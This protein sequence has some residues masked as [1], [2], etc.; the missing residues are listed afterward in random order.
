[1][2]L[3]FKLVML[4]VAAAFAAGVMA[5]QIQAGTSRPS[6][7]VHAWVIGALIVLW[8][9]AVLR[10][11]LV[12]KFQ[13]RDLPTS[14]WLRSR[15]R[16]A[17]AVFSLPMLVS[18]IWAY[19]WVAG[20]ALPHHRT[21]RQI[22]GLTGIAW[23]VCLVM[24]L[25]SPRPDVSD[26]LPPHAGASPEV[27]EVGYSRGFGWAFLTVIAA[28]TVW[29]SLNVF[30]GIFGNVLTQIAGVTAILVWLPYFLIAAKSGIRAVLTSGPVLV[31]DE[32]GITDS[33]R[34]PSFASWE[35][36]HDV[37]LGVGGRYY[38]L[39][40]RFRSG[41]TARQYV[42]RFFRLRQILMRFYVLGDWNLSL[43]LLGRSRTDIFHAAQMH[44]RAYIARKVIRRAPPSH[45]AGV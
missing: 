19:L 22:I 18:L 27:L 25:R 8:H 6:W 34:E 13:G 24:Y 3:R 44:R 39:C 26:A 23:V 38:T 20:S 35:D 16:H 43:W 10:Q 9:H 12:R 40:V 28:V 21:G 11:P 1:M 45:P 41:V 29:L 37:H 42:G 4:A 2:T 15:V 33:R 5:W 32:H 31:V 17:L 30:I 14:P 7:L 36:I